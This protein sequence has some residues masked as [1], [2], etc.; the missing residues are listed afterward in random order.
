LKILH[1]LTAPRAEGTPQLVLDWMTVSGHEQEVLFMN[2]QPDDLHK[3]FQ[4]TG[5]KLHFNLRKISGSPIKKGWI[6]TLAVRS[7]CRKAKPAVVISWNQGYSHWT[8]L[9]ARLAGVRK[10]IAHGGNPPYYSSLRQIL[11]NWYV[12]WPTVAMGAKMICCSQ[13][14]LDEFRK[15]PVLPQRI[16]AAVPN[17]VQT[18][19]FIKDNGT[20]QPPDNSMNVIMVAT[21]E[22]HKDHQT[23]LRAWGLVEKQNKTATLQLVGSGSLRESLEKFSKA[24]ALSRVEFLGSRNDIPEL[25]WKSRLFVFSTT[26]QEGF[27]IVLIEALAAGLPVVATD[28]PACREVLQEGKYGTLVPAGDHLKL[29][30]AIIGKLEKSIGDKERKAQVEYAK[31]FSPENMMEKYISVA[32]Q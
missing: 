9:G 23:L 7:V 19:R 25:L 18:L 32:E 11:Y 21:M 10:L 15:V 20:Q 29:A 24:L 2:T 27:G 26:G 6:M 31:V 8:L 4:A 22:S 13:Y 12:A 3:D 17:C 5:S 14:I 30:E 16:F 28:V 1:I